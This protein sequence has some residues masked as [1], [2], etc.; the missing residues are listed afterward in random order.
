MAGLHA[1]NAACFLFGTMVNCTTP[2]PRT[3]SNRNGAQQPTITA[4]TKNGDF[5]LTR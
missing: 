1:G 2:A 5:A 3:D 4:G